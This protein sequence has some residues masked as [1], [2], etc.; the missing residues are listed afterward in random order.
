MKEIY[1]SLFFALWH[2]SHQGAWEQTP[3]IESDH[4]IKIQALEKSQFFY[5]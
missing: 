1:R 4:E 5:F 3:V 2:D